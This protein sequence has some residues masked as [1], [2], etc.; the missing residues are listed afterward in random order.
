MTLTRTLSVR[1]RD[2]APVDPVRTN[3]QVLDSRTTERI[4]FEIGV[5]W[6]ADMCSNSP[7]LGSPA[8]MTRPG[9]HDPTSN[10]PAV[11][12]G[13][14]DVESASET[15]SATARKHEGRWE[16]LDRS[17]A[18]GVAFKGDAHEKARTRQPGG[19]RAIWSGTPG[20]NRRPSPSNQASGIRPPRTPAGRRL[21]LRDRAEQQA[22]RLV[23]VPS[24]PPWPRGAPAP[25]RRATPR[26]AAGPRPQQ[27]SAGRPRS[28]DKAPP[29]ARA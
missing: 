22:T 14:L 21:H 7:S 17:R 24:G 6:G 12:Q 13:F 27:R 11:F 15:R 19:I 5:Q 1:D 2:R 8:M 25:R 29:A 3:R 26:R 20:S 28:R 4:E 9:R 16:T 23:T 18:H 10:V